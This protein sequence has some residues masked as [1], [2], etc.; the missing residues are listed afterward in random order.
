MAE[1][2][3]WILDGTLYGNVALRVLEGVERPVFIPS[4]PYG[5][6]LKSLLVAPL[7]GVMDPARAFALASVLFYALFVA[8]LY[9]LTAWLFESQ[10]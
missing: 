7:A 4:Q 5:G 2:V 6:T 9:R 8:G 1:W 10:L 3:D